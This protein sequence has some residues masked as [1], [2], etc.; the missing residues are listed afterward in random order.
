[1]KVLEVLKEAGRYEEVMDALK[2]IKTDNVTLPVHPFID[3]DNITKWR[4]EC[5]KLAKQRDKLMELIE[6][7]V[8][9]EAKDTE[10][11]DELQAYVETQRDMILHNYAISIS[12]RKEPKENMEKARVWCI[13]ASIIYETFSDYLDEEQTKFSIPDGW[14]KQS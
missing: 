2:E 6:A 1:M 9:I 10:N 7:D 11:M 4:V 8:D 14:K 12:H 5:T 3:S 13:I